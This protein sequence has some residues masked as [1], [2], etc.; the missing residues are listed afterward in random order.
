MKVVKRI[1]AAVLIGSLVLGTMALPAEAGGWG[2]RGHGHYRVYGGHGHFIGGFLPGIAA[3]VILGTI[4]AP[5]YY[6]YDAPRPVYQAPAPV[7]QDA[8]VPGHWVVR[9]YADSPGYERFWVEGY[10]EQRCY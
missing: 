9:R 6:Y 10:W 4:F 7:C 1:G 5:R 3:G 2:R 8:W